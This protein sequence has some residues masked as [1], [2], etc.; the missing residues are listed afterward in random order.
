MVDV[1]LDQT[2]HLS[3]ISARNMC[4]ASACL[5]CFSCL[6][7]QWA[8]FNIAVYL[9]QA[10][11]EFCS[12]CCCSLVRKRNLV[13]TI[14]GQVLINI[15]VI[16]VYV[17]DKEY[18]SSDYDINLFGRSLQDYDKHTINYQDID[19]INNVEHTET[20]NGTEF[21]SYSRRERIAEYLDVAF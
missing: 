17:I 13:I 19:I 18:F 15:A 12:R 7:A 20:Y 3:Y 9:F 10:M 16:T 8:T 1:D 5:S 2:K 4:T 21:S 11:S 6:A 14:I